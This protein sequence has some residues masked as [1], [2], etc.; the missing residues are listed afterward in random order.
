MKKLLFPLL[1]G[2]L[3]LPVL[4]VS[5]KKDYEETEFSGKVVYGT[6]CSTQTYG[7]VIALDSPAGFGQE[8]EIGGVR[9]PNAV[10][11]YESPKIL[12]DQWKVSGV[13]YE[14]KGYGKVH[15]SLWSDYIN[16]KEVIFLEVNH[17]N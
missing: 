7:Y 1:F 5:C 9:Y 6:I 10:I 8:V 13:F 15:C 4:F 2:A 17:D 14:T 11:G 16:M 12:K 3:C